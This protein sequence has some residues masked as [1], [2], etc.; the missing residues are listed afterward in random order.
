MKLKFAVLVF[1]GYLTFMSAGAFAYS[2]QL[3]SG[4]GDWLTSV[5][6]FDILEYRAA[7]ATATTGVPLAAPGIALDWGIT[8]AETHHPSP[9][10]SWP[11]RAWIFQV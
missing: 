1:G 8:G 4:S 11:G 5:G 2:V 3:V 6:E 10:G 9:N 7:D